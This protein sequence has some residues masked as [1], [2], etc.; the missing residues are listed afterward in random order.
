[1]QKPDIVISEIDLTR[2]EKL[3]ANM[4]K[5]NAIRIALEEE[6]DRAD[7]VSP[8]EMPANVVTMNSTVTFSLNDAGEAFTFTLVYP[9]DMQENGETISILAP[10]GSAMLGLKVGD[11]ISWPSADGKPLMVSVADISYQPERAGDLHR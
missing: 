10:A 5:T 3:L 7:I 6:L 2:I 8:E 1:M 9:Q 4:P 11:K